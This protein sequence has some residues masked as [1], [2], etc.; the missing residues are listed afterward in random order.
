MSTS[1]LDQDGL[2]DYTT[3]LVAKLKTIL[4]TKSDIGTPLT[5]ATA[6]AMT[7]T[8][9]IYVY[10][11]SETGYVNG[12]WYYWNG[13]AWADGGQYNASISVDD[14]LSIQGYAADAKATGDLKADKD[15]YYEDL[16]VGRADNIISD[17]A[18][19]DKTP[20]LIRATGGSI[21][22]GDTVKQKAI[23]GVSSRLYQRDT[24]VSSSSSSVNGWIRANST[25]SGLTLSGRTYTLSS[26]SN[27]STTKNVRSTNSW[28]VRDHIFFC[29]ADISVTDSST[30]GY[31]SMGT[32]SASG[33]KVT[34]FSVTG[35]T[36][37]FVHKAAIKK[38]TEQSALT[39]KFFMRLNNAAPTDSYMQVRELQV[40]DISNA[41]GFDVAEYL[42]EREN[43]QA[44][45]GVAIFRS[46]FS[47]KYYTGATSG[48][49]SS[50]MPDKKVCIGFNIYNSTT[51]KAKVLPNQQYMIEGNYTSYTYTPE[52]SL[53]VTTVSSSDTNASSPT[54]DFAGELVFTGA[55]SDLCVHLK[56]DGSR[57]GEKISYK[58]KE[59]EFENVGS[60]RGYFKLDAS[61]NIYAY[62]DTYTSD[63]NITR[64]MGSIKMNDLTWT[65]D[66]TNTRF[67]ASVPNLKLG[68]GS[69]ALANAWDRYRGD[70]SVMP[71][72]SVWFEEN[73]YSS[74]NLVIKCLSYT[75]VTDFLASIGAS[76]FVYELDTPTIESAT[77]YQETQLI[78]NWGMEEYINDGTS[79]REMPYGHISYYLQDLKAKVESAP[80]APNIDGLYLYKRENGVNTYVPLTNNAY[81]INTVQA[82]MT[83][84]YTIDHTFDEIL[85]AYNGGQKIVFK[86]ALD[87]FIGSADCQGTVSDSEDNIVMFN[88]SMVDVENGVLLAAY[89]AEDSGTA[90]ARTATYS[91]Q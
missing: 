16:S 30:T 27:T 21:E 44:G 9:K 19:I 48:G 81:E 35:P 85:T 25:Y 51:N 58:A 41:L 62:G 83:D 26:K 13:T 17:V 50:V 72:Y 73:V 22:A 91:L 82:V 65:Y 11:G 1:Y 7:D 84:T 86:I 36:N 67:Y 54:F 29:C 24:L 18:A 87:D 49:I 89:I 33:S 23:I 70:L 5:A 53:V 12:H 40:I 64:C 79:D 90:Y 4:A 56:Y 31:L 6:A 39:G 55:D 71:D 8:T 15:G 57:D 28:I 80:N 37:G 46:L 77:P 68:G 14:T 10:T 47:K 45:A 61:N 78:D 76:Y 88:F 69:I 2:Q 59:Y 38:Y 20:Y 75:T 74:T 60:L 63:G 52:G 43:A 3:K 32:N 66:S 42:L 34:F